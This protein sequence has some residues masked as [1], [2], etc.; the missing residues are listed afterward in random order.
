VVQGQGC[1]VTCS[2]L[3]GVAGPCV[4]VWIMLPG[5]DDYD[6]CQSTE[7]FH[8]EEPKHPLRSPEPYVQLCLAYLLMVCVCSTLLLPSG[9]AA[10]NDVFLYMELPAD[11]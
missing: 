1:G 11:L 3:G 8:T 7:W 5:E 10:A 2:L 9:P 6:I 4:V